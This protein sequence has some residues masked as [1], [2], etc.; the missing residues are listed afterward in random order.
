MLLSSVLGIRLPDY[1]LVRKFR[2]RQPA[3]HHV[4]RTPKTITDNS[5]RLELRKNPRV[6]T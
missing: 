1:T 5:L 2:L 3:T 4:T 6:L